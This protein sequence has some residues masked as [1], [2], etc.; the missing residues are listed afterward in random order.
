ML[1]CIS[2]VIS[3]ISDEPAH[4]RSLVRA[5]AALAHK[6][7]KKLKAQTKNAHSNRYFTKMRYYQ[8]S[9]ELDQIDK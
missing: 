2:Y 5:F 6:V 3:E 9:N 1:T 4:S 8:N 7:E